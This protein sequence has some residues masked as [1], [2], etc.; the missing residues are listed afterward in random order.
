MTVLAAAQQALM[1]LMGRRPPSVLASDDQ[2]EVEISALI[3]DAGEDIAKGSDWQRLTREHIITGD[4]VTEAHSLPAD[5]DRMILA[6][7]VMTTDGWA[8]VYR[9]ILAP[10][11]WRALRVASFGQVPPGNWILLGGQMRFWPVIPSGQQ[12]QYLYQSNLIWTDADGNPRASVSQDTDSFVLPERLLTLALIWRY[13]QMKGMDYAEELRSYETA[14]TQEMARD[15][16]G[17]SITSRDRSHL[18]RYDLRTAYPWPL[19]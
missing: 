2:T 15:R 5:Y 16:G 18:R 17:R 11:E 12:A 8:R 13:R 6:G 14:L 3:Q 10:D 9:H 19:G 1:V 7:E 4:G